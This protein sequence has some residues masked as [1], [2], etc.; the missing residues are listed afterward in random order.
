MSEQTKQA[1]QETACSGDN[2]QLWIRNG[3]SWLIVSAQFA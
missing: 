3:R 1:G 2:G